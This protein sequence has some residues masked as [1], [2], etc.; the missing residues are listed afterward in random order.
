MFDAWVGCIHLALGQPEVLAAFRRETGNKWEPGRA[1]LDRMIDDATDANWQFIKA[2][3]KWA[4][5]H[6]WGPIDG[7]ELGADD[8]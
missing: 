1:P 2:F 8:V 6:V 5:V 4:N 3:V 7:A